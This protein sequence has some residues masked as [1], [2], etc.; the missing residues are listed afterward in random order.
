MYIDF[1]KL[2][3]FCLGADD[4]VSETLNLFIQKLCFDESFAFDETEDD[5]ELE[6]PILL[7][8]NSLIREEILVLGEPIKETKKV[9]KK[10]TRGN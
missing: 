10:P 4:N 3:E 8:R 2:N 7:V 5:D 1:K 9:I 6:I